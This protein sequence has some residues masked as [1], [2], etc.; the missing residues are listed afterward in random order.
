MCVCVFL[1]VCMCVFVFYDCKYEYNSGF[2][3]VL[4]KEHFSVYALLGN[5]DRPTNHPNDQHTDIRVH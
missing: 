2:K 1:C 4:R 5:Y 3:Q